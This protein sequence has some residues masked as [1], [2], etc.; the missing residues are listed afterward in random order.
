[1]ILRKEE[2]RGREEKLK[3]ALV[4]FTCNVTLYVLLFTTKHKRNFS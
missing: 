2:R 1:M 3:G 4:D